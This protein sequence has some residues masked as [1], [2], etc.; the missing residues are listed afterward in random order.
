MRNEGRG[1]FI[2]H[3][4]RSFLYRWRS[5][6]SFSLLLL[7]PLQTC[8]PS[9]RRVSSINL[10]SVSPSCQPHF[11]NCSAWVLSMACSPTG[12]VGLSESPPQGHKS[13]QKTWSSVGSSLHWTTDSVRSLFQCRL[14]SGSQPPLGNQSLQPGVHLGLQMD[15]C[16][17]MDLH[18]LQGDNL[19]HHDLLHGLQG[20]LC[21]CARAPP[22]PP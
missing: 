21:S 22:P 14:P 2:T 15:H 18:G 9:H 4:Y 1:Q 12:R 20:H 3:L 5:P 10:S 11:K 8:G 6:H 17:T 16:S 7:T 13:C 19:P